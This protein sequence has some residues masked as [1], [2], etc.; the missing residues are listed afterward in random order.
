MVDK[1]Q[2]TLIFLFIISQ[3][4]QVQMAGVQPVT[5]SRGVSFSLLFIAGLKM[6]LLWARRELAN[7]RPKIDNNELTITQPW[8]KYMSI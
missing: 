1:R 4:R 6:S 2:A 5:M 8:E 3:S 7:K